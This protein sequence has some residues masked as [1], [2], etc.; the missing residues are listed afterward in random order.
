[1]SIHKECF[2]KVNGIFVDVNMTIKQFE[3]IDPIK[4]L[5]SC[6]FN[7]GKFRVINIFHDKN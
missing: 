5:V 6:E 1:M 7:K 2:C 4:D 3:D